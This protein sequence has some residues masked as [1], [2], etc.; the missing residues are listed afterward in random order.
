MYKVNKEKFCSDLVITKS[1]FTLLLLLLN[2]V[3]DY[4]ANLHLYGGTIYPTIILE[5][6]FAIILQKESKSKIFIKKF[7]SLT[8]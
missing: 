7:E 1:V 6:S 5:N 2:R 8:I 4:N 3:L